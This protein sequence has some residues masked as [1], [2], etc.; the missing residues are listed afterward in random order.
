[1]RHEALDP[2][3]ETGTPARAR[4]AERRGRFRIEPPLRVHRYIFR[5]ADGGQR[6]VALEQLALAGIVEDLEA[7]AARLLAGARVLEPLGAGVARQIVD[8]GG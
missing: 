4:R 6:V 2:G 7:A 5:A 3:A 1:V 8:V